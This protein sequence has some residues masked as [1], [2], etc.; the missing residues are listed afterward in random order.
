MKPPTE[1]K[2]RLPE[3]LLKHILT[4]R[5]GMRSESALVESPTLDISN[6][7]TK[8][9]WAEE[10]YMCFSIQTPL[11]HP[12]DVVPHSSIFQHYHNT[13]FLIILGKG[14]STAKL[15]RKTLAGSPP[16]SILRDLRIQSL[17][18]II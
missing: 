14:D 12:L 18:A 5:L 7:S 15:W 17:L 10:H 4:Y 8:R 2:A 3:C 6:L 16:Y 13:R 1:L 11:P 9:L